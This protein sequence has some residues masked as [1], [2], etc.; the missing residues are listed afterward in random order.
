MRARPM[1]DGSEVADEYDV[2]Q[3][4]LAAAARRW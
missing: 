3:V 4:T 2:Y 1:E